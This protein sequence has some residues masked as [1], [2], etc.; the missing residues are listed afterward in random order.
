M[1]FFLIF[2][3]KTSVTIQKIKQKGYRFKKLFPFFFRDKKKRNWN[4]KI[5]S[6]HEVKG[7]NHLFFSNLA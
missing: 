5:H 4:G 6:Y 1:K 3:L 7:I 2:N